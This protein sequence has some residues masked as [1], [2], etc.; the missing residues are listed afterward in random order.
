MSDNWKEEL[1]K[2]LN[3][4]NLT[5]KEDEKNVHIRTDSGSNSR[6]SVGRISSICLPINS[7]KIEINIKEVIKM[8][9]DKDA[10]SDL[11]KIEKEEGVSGEVKIVRALKVVIKFLSTMRSNQLLTDEDKAAIKKARIERQEKKETK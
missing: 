7:R 6:N 8:I 4:L 5:E 2:K 11:E 9:T 1:D 10:L 3:S